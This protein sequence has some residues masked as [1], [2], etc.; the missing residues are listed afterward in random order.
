MERA[1]P[2]SVRITTVL[3]AVLLAVT[4]LA[5]AAG[6]GGGPF[7]DVDPDAY[8][9]PAVTWLRDQGLT[10]GVGGS[11]RFEPLRDISRGEVATLLWRRAG[12]PPAP[13][14]P[15]VDVDPAAYYGDA[16]AW[17]A[18]EGLT[19]GVAGSDR[20][21]PGRPITRAEVA[22]L[23]WRAEGRPTGGDE[24]FRDVRDGTFYTDAVRWMRADRITSGYG[25]T[26]LFLPDRR[27][28][29]AEVATFLWRIGT[30]ALAPLPPEPSLLTGRRMVAL[31]GHPGAPVLGVLGEQDVRASIDRV[32]QVAAP[33]GADGRE[34]LPAFE[35]IATVASS[36]A[37]ADGDYSAESSVAELRPWVDAAGAAGVYVVLDLQPGR[38]DFLTQARLYEELLREPHVGLALD[39]EWRLAPGERHL[40][41]V[42][43]VDAAEV[44]TV[45]DW[46]ADLTADAGLPDKLLLLHQF[47]L[48]MITNREAI[49][50]RPELEIVIQMDGNGTAAQKYA[51]YDALTSGVE[52]RWRWGWKNFYDEDFP[53]FTPSEVLALDPVP[54]FVS[55]Q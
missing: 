23:L 44:Q 19:T 24:T 6:A 43:S 4:G 17:L 52:D 27:I 48:D 21:E 29:R 40:E 45:V 38:T 37:G 39:P 53:T 51:T 42:G 33:Y 2:R 35:I 9:G 7:D 1:L 55:Y 5:P 34:V 36:S 31:Y 50:P 15:F 14:A 3:A 18:E 25:R 54:V 20:F 26:G 46:L 49:V 22:T 12:S 13:G 47:R 28:S 32:R 8:Y 16:V 41:Q 10:T 11:N 30:G